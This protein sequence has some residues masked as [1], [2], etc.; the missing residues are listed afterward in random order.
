MLFSR[1][2]KVVCL[3]VDRRFDQ[4]QERVEQMLKSKGVDKVNWFIDGRGALLHPARYDQITPQPPAGWLHGV[5]AY[6]HFCAVQAVVARAKDEGVQ[7]LLF[8]EDDCVLTDEFDSVLADANA[9]IEGRQLRWSLLYYGAN[10]TWAA[11]EQLAPNILRCF[12]SYTTHCM[13]ISCSFFD[14]I[15]QLKPDHVIDKVIGDVLHEKHLCLAIWP[16]IAV[17][18]PGYSLLSYQPCD[19]TDLFKN[20]GAARP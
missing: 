20:Q 3:C 2:D 9:Q 8:V 17:Q 10:H 13:G 15:L 7:N 6:A 1:Y 5:G 11:T 18:K 4:E 12:G 19:Y 14:A 16:A